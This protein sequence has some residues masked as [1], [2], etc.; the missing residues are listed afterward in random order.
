M[1]NNQKNWS[2]HV[3]AEL[4]DADEHPDVLVSEEPNLLSKAATLIEIHK[5]RLTPP[6]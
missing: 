3:S 2:Q 6:V 1:S 4:T 5:Q